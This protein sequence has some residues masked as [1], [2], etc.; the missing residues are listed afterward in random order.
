MRESWTNPISDAALCVAVVALVWASTAAGQCLDPVFSVAVQSNVVYGTG[1]VDDG[2]AQ[3]D[4][5]LDVYTPV[6]DLRTDKPAAVIVHGGSF[7][8]GSK[9]NSLMVQ[10]GQ[11]LA[12]RGFVA[13]SINYRL[14][15]DDPPVPTWMQL[16]M[17]AF[18]ITP[19]HPE[20]P[21]FRTAHAA[22]MDTRIAVR[23]LRE[24]AGLYGI[25][26]NRIAG[27]GSSA[28]AFCTL[29]AGVIDEPGFDFDHLTPGD[30]ILYASQSPYTDVTV[31]LWGTLAGFLDFVLD[32]DDTPVMIAHGTNDTVVPYSEAQALAD[33]AVVVGLDHELWPLVGVGHGAPLT[34]DVSGEPLSERILDFL[35][36]RLDLCSCN[37]PG[38]GV[39][40]DGTD[41]CP[42]DP[43]KCYKVRDLGNPS[44]DRVD[45]SLADQ[46][47]INDGTFSL[48]K[49]AHLC[50]PST[51]DGSAIG[52]PAEHLVCYK[53]KGPALATQQRPDIA[54]DNLFGPLHLQITKPAMLC[55][56]STKT[57][58]P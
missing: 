40:I 53:M 46:F 49:P 43:F 44:F 1:A 20:Y 41:L 32:G 16:I 35:S 52:N 28:G 23:W 45:V 7:T 29:V 34:V 15:G 18:G 8:G 3:M 50:N 12:A 36:S 38:G 2:A 51:V 39:A 14:F 4:L 33:R 26:P 55:V 24:N 17:N 42:L 37:A 13:I 57:V 21:R 30:P 5:L 54:V 22:G 25:D 48:L 58:L 6:G 31:D 47:G 9:T 10:L 27:I 19:A 11:L 56:P